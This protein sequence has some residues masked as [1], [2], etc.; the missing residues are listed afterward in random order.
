[1]IPRYL[2]SFDLSALPVKETDV[3]VIGGGIAGLIAALHAAKKCR[4]AILSK[5]KPEECATYKAQGGI[6]AVVDPSDSAISHFKDTVAA[7]AGLCNE[8]AV[9][10]MA[11]EAKE[12]IEE[13]V[14]L[15]MK[16]D[17]TNSHFD[18]GLE[19]GHSRARIL[20]SK[21]GTGADI[22]KAL[23]AAA[24]KEMHIEQLEGYCIDIITDNKDK[25]TRG[26]VCINKNGELF[27]IA[28]K[29]TIMAT[30]GAG[31]L[32]ENTTNPDMA[33]GDGIAIAYRAGA[34]L[35]DLE[36]VQFHPTVFCKKGFPRFMITEGMRGAGAVLLNGNGERFMP[37]YDK[38]TELAPRDIVSR[39]IQIEME[40][41]GASFV[42]LDATGI[43]DIVNRFPTVYKTC[44]E[45]GIDASRDRIPVAPAAHYI[46]G[47][48]STD[49]YG[50]T[51]V[52]GLFACGECACAG[53]HGANRLASNS[54]LEGMVFGKRAGESAAQFASDMGNVKRSVAGAAA[55]QK[56]S[57]NKIAGR[58]DSGEPG[59]AKIK[60][61]MNRHGWI[62]RSGAGL[63]KGIAELERM[64]DALKHDPRNVRGYEFRNTL[65]LSRLILESA[66]AREESRGAH[67][68][69]DFQ[70]R[71]D[72]NWKR[73]IEIRRQ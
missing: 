53:V 25:G 18:F 24:Q 61:I 46:M 37:K 66:L 3:L 8:D 51:S 21:D 35:S 57:G 2:A 14:A 64:E 27:F 70:E 63:R 33:T 32:F 23:V 13:L 47:G 1:M 69:S 48:V 42:Y 52:P 15:G 62:V 36:F 16:F 34:L 12:R 26:A 11:S 22:E 9:R 17:R 38:R 10:V 39:A 72:V 43:T 67:Q 65:I 49:L 59:A 71:D 50:Q 44:M 28:S 5:S 4:V 60:S 30:G 41:G 29:A 68:R 55:C 6:A 58:V 7:G 31:Q 19:G 40:I 73:H 56:E 54:L 45:Y 20:H